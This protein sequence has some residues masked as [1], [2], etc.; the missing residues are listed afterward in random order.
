MPEGSIAIATDKN[1]AARF[2]VGTDF[3]TQLSGTGWRSAAPLSLFSLMLPYDQRPVPQREPL[4]RTSSTLKSSGGS[5]ALRSATKQFHEPCWPWSRQRRA[6]LSL[7]RLKAGRSYSPPPPSLLLL[8]E[9]LERH[10]PEAGV[11]A[12]NVRLKRLVFVIERLDRVH[13]REL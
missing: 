8:L 13:I 5:S 7:R 12:A 3:G 4:A 10:D 2:A 9:A 1:L 11:F 6:M